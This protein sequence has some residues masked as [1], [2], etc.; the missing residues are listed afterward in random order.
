MNKISKN[1]IGNASMPM[2]SY[3]VSRATSANTGPGSY[4]QEKIHGQRKVSSTVFSKVG[5]FNS[6]MVER[7]NKTPVEK[8]HR[9]RVV[10]KEKQFEARRFGIRGGGR[11][12]VSDE[13]LFFNNNENVSSLY[14]TRNISTHKTTDISTYSPSVVSFN[15]DVSERQPKNIKIKTPASFMRKKIPINNSRDSY[16]N[17]GTKK[18]CGSDL[19]FENSHY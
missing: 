18:S 12:N 17:Q 6:P 2:S 3:I 9:S 11:S 4:H 19:T 16:V 15:M 13:I 14:P 1:E 7:S 8:N 5:R 10:S